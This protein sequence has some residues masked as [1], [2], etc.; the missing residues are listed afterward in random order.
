MDQ[1]GEPRIGVTDVE[2]TSRPHIDTNRFRQKRFGTFLRHLAEHTGGLDRI[3][4]LDIGG[5][6]AYWE[7]VRA[8]WGHLPIEVTFVNLGARTVDRPP[9]FIRGGNG[10]HLPEFADGSFHAVHSNSVIEHVGRWPEMQAMATEIRRL[11]AHY[12][13]QTPNFGFPYEPHFRTPFFHWYPEAVR[14]RMM[15]RRK[16]GFYERAETLDTAVRQVQAVNLLTGDQV[17]AL[18][19]DGTVRFERVLGLKKSIMV[20]R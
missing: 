18:F 11:A 4:V 2:L 5:V 20:M 7:G 19:P 1:P 14:A 10:C 12:F 9:Y 16:H 6:V 13:V 3:R 17:Q 15:L 8:L